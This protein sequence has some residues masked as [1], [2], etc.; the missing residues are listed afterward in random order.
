MPGNDGMVEAK[1]VVQGSQEPIFRPDKTTGRHGFGA[2]VPMSGWTCLQ[3]FSLD[4]QPS[5]KER[6]RTGRI[7]RHLVVYVPQT[8]MVE[9]MTPSSKNLRFRFCVRTVG[10]ESPEVMCARSLSEVRA[11]VRDDV[12]AT[13]PVWPPTLLMALERYNL[14]QEQFCALAEK[15]AEWL[16]P[17]AKSRGIHVVW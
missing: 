7:S 17:Y 11:G 3:T 13:E 16:R 12:S 1:K 9:R 8:A 14:T 2:D 15:A 10:Q 6:S 5:N 4:P